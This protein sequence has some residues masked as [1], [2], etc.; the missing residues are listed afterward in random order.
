MKF[1]R[2]ET[3]SITHANMLFKVMVREI[4]EVL[5]SLNLLETVGAPSGSPQ[6]RKGRCKIMEMIECGVALLDEVVRQHSIKSCPDEEC[7]FNV[8]P[9]RTVR[10]TVLLKERLITIHGQYAEE[11]AN[12]GE[13]IVPLPRDIMVLLT[14]G[15]EDSGQKPP[16]TGMYL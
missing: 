2:I 3:E 15:F 10:N 14:N 12:A 8:S 11:E 16:G 6:V 7:E 5:N 9:E 4:Q 1:Y 13:E